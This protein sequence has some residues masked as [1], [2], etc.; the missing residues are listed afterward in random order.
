MV[1]RFLHALVVSAALGA[2]YAWNF[3]AGSSQQ[4][5]P[6]PDA[7]SS[8][9]KSVGMCHR[10]NRACATAAYWISGDATDVRAHFKPRAAIQGDWLGS[11]PK[12]PVILCV[13]VLVFAHIPVLIGDPTSFSRSQVPRPRRRPALRRSN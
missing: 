11:M 13:V 5:M 4:A 9:P 8:V 12:H 10:N 3:R 1:A 7:G 2:S 6:P